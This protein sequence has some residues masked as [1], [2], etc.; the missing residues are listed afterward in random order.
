MQTIDNFNFTGKKVSETVKSIESNQQITD[1]QEKINIQQENKKIYK[2]NSGDKK[3][4][5]PATS[6]VYSTILKMSQQGFQVYSSGSNIL[7]LITSGG[8]Q[9]REAR[10]SGD[11]GIIIGR[12]ISQFNNEGINT[13]IVRMT[14]AIIGKYIQEELTLNNQTHHIEYF[15]E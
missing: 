4:W 6:E 9:I 13:E 11:G 3:S 7:T 15:E 5:E 10:D 12:I 2:L 14:K 8:F 1:K